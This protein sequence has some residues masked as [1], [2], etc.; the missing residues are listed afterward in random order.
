MTP[1]HQAV[2]DLYLT[3]GKSYREIGDGFG[4]TRNKVAGILSRHLPKDAPRRG[5][6]SAVCR[7]AENHWAEGQDLDP[8]A[9]RRIL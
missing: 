8:A 3:S 1:E 6:P 5:T 9:T 4:Y 2:I 7:I